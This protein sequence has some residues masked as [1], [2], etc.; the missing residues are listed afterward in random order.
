MKFIFPAALRR[1]HLMK[2]IWYVDPMDNLQPL[3][4]EGILVIGKTRVKIK[5][6]MLSESGIKRYASRDVDFKKAELI[7]AGRK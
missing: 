7:R 5:N 4:K 3:K 6:I 1:L 2:K